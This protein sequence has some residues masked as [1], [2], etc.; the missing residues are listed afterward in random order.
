M[1]NLSFSFYDL[2]YFLLI[3]VRVSCFVFIAPFFSLGGTPRQVR[4]V[5]SFFTSALL[6]STLAPAPAILYTSVMEYAIMVMKEAIAGLIIG[7]GSTICTAIVNLAGSIVDMETGL[8]MTT[9]MDPTSKENS[10]VTGVFYQYT[11]MLMLIVS[12]MYRYLFGALA[13]SFILI[14]VNG[15]IFNSASL[16]NSMITFLT[17]YLMIGFTICLPMFCVSLLLNSIL[18][19]LTKVSPQMNM[20]AIG[21]QLKILVGLSV[22]FFTAAILPYVS[23]FIFSE[24]KKMT[25][26]FVLEGMM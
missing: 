4:I 21:I 13:E 6:Y 3:F 2:E 11:V 25:V 16:L 14:P 15:A 26:A 24:M 20:F 9:I 17:D 18:G 8:S 1:L 10:S 5:L 23:D 19:V 12:G 7:F 22:M